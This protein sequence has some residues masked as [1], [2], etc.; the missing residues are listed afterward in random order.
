[1]IIIRDREVQ[2]VSSQYGGYVSLSDMYTLYEGLNSANQKSRKL[3]VFGPKLSHS[4]CIVL[5][6]NIGESI[7]EILVRMS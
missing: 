7:N 6:I 5:L 1:M 2:S 4:H 3:G